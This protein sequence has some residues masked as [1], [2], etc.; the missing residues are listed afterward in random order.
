MRGIVLAGGAGVGMASGIVMSRTDD[1][2]T[3]GALSR[4]AERVEHFVTSP[5]ALVTLVTG[6]WLLVDF[7]FFDVGQTWLWLAYVLWVVAVALGEGVLAPHNKRLHLEAEALARA[8]IERSAE[9]QRAA[10]SP[11]GTVTGLVLTLLLL[12]FVYLMVVKPGA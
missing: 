12:V 1:V 4:V 5:G 9:L 11:R 8:G 3:I 7:D 10:A 2:R 6:T